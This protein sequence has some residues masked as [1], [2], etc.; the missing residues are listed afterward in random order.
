MTD[1]KLSP[2]SLKDLE[3]DTTCPLRFKG[4]RIDKLFRTEPTD[5]MVMGLYF[6]TLVF[7][8]TAG[9]DT[10]E[11]L[12]KKLPKTS[13]GKQ[14]IEVTRMKLQAERVRSALYNPDDPDYLGYTIKN[15]QSTLYWEDRAKCI[16]DFDAVNENGDWCLFDL[17]LTKDLS[18][19]YGPYAWGNVEN[20]DLVQQIICQ[21]AWEQEY[22]MEL[23]ENNILVVDY[24]PSTRIKLI[25][26]NVMPYS[27]DITRDRI[28][29]AYDVLSH[30]M[31]NGFPVD[32][33]KEEC[34]E[35]Q[36]DCG[37]RYKEPS[38]VTIEIDV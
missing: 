33:S 13:A 6:E 9:D 32:P 23:A 16:I 28:D 34:S 11:E 17:K 27:V 2:T 1:W 21:Q 35:C 8:S 10:L 4:Q 15:T 12:E 22:G 20:M 36:L 26:L 30:Y 24:S 38:I 31:E 7:G 19:T 29:T 18:N 37:F 25:K 14:P 3:K 5:P